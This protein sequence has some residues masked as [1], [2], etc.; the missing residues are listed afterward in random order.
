MLCDCGPDICW[1]QVCLEVRWS[2]Y[3]NDETGFFIFFFLFVIILE[4]EEFCRRGHFVIH[5]ENV[6][7]QVMLHTWKTQLQRRLLQELERIR[8]EHS[9]R[10]LMNQ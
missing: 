3:P 10:G 9:V 1:L 7:H 5:A 2:V 6:R 4:V 8:G